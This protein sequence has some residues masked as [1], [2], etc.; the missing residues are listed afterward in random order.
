LGS[1][2]PTPRPFLSHRVMFLPIFREAIRRH[3]AAVLRFQPG[4]LARRRRIADAVTGGPP[5]L[6]GGG[7]PHRISPLDPKSRKMLVGEV[8]LA[9]GPGESS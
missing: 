2:S 9:V 1:R 3:Q 8:E 6:C 5:D 7:I 4:S